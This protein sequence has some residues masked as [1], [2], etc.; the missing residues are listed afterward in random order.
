MKILQVIPYFAPAW[1]FGGPVKVCY[2]ISKELV[3]DGHQITVWTT[4]ASDGQ[5]PI[6]VL[7]E[8]IDGIFVKRFRNVLPKLTHGYNV[9]TPIGFSNYAEKEI[10]SYDLV[11]C[12]SFFTYQNIIISKLCKSK[13]IP[14]IIHLHEMPIPHTMLG[15][16]SIKIIFNFFFGKSIL[17]NAT[18]IIVVSPREK[19]LL[20]KYLPSVDKKIEVVPNPIEP[21]QAKLDKK[22]AQ[23]N[24]KVIL[25]LGRLSFIKG[26]DRLIRAFG[27]LIKKDSS[28]RLI[29]AGPDENNNLT[30]LTNLAKELGAQDKVEFV[31]LV[32]KAQKEEVFKRADIFALFSLYESFSIATLE[33]LQHDLPCCLSKNIGVASQIETA[34]C[35]IIINNIEDSSECAEKLALTYEMRY[36]LSRNCARSLAP[37]ELSRVTLLITNIYKEIIS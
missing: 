34:G 32:S 15:K 1:G 29:I 19:E 4:D 22:E 2:Q 9:F 8:T 26:L 23:K 11:H 6:K 12:H 21:Y 13:K 17:K 5:T 14:Y 24:E 30:K 37:F 31:G 28:Y 10:S 33:A 35:G 36:K 18:R 3:K 16:K 7:D 25:F 27:E 20:A